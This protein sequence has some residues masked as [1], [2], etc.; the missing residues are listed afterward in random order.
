MVN[1]YSF[2]DGAIQFKF[3]FLDYLN[4][5][6]WLGVYFRGAREFLYSSYLLYIRKNGSI[7]L[8]L[9]PGP[10]VIEKIN[11]GKP[12]ILNQEIELVLE[13]ENNEL[14]VKI[15]GQSFQFLSLEK[16]SIGHIILAT[17]E[18][19]AQF[20]DIELINRD[21]TLIGLFS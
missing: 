18:C 3:K 13:I 14:A 4:P 19:Q 20:R 11:F 2:R 12:E 6:S 7:E 17:W 15:N 10:N 9:Y 21:T 5:E 8:A 16:Q 1:D